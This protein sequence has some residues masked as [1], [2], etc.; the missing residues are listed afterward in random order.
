MSE[1]MNAK[2]PPVIE[3]HGGDSR[4]DPRPAYGK[5]DET[6]AWRYGLTITGPDRTDVIYLGTTEYGSESAAS[7]AVTEYR[8][9]RDVLKEMGAWEHVAV[10]YWVQRQIRTVTHR[11]EA[12]QTNPDPDPDRTA[13]RGGIREPI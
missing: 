5:P 9:R 3:P 7:L 10:H 2:T 6:I 11:W 4:D 12:P 13:Q 8:R 1:L